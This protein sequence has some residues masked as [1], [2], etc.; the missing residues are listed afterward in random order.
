[1]EYNAA[2]SLLG[3]IALIVTGQA[4]VVDGGLITAMGRLGD[5]SESPLASALA[6]LVGETPEW[7][8]SE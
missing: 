4:F 2:R 1:M 6:D 3:A 5:V 8:G 7:M